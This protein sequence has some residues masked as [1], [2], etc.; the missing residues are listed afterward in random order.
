M[1]QLA[2]AVDQVAHML[3]KIIGSN[4]FLHQWYQLLHKL[5]VMIP[6]KGALATQSICETLKEGLWQEELSRLLDVA[7]IFASQEQSFV[8]KQD[9]LQ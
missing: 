5:D 7:A 1:Q 9:D 8:L 6:N 4:H 3:G 2:E